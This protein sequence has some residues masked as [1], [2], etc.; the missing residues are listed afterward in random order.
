LYALRGRLLRGTAELIAGCGCE[1]GCPSCVGPAGETGDGAKAAAR[2]LLEGL[3]DGV[4]TAVA[5]TA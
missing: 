5:Q 1:S 3:L 4:D 2:L